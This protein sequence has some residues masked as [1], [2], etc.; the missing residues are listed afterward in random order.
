MQSVQ[1]SHVARRARSLAAILDFYV[2]SRSEA[3]GRAPEEVI[4]FGYRHY[5][6]SPRQVKSE[7]L[8]FG[9]LV[10]EWSPKVLVEIG[11]HA[12]GTFFVLCRCAHPQATVISIDLPGARFSG[13][14]PK[15][16]EHLLP[17]M[18]LKT[19][20]LHRLRGNSHESRSLIWLQSVLRGRQVDVMLIDGDH[21]YKGVKEDFAM[22]SPHVRK[23]GI[24][25]LH[26]IVDHTR[27]PGCEVN[28]FW[29]E[30]KESY[31]HDELIEDPSQGWAGIG[32]LY[33]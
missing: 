13:G 27:D 24:I 29:R 22:Y 17:R 11:T 7:I 6:V 31:R 20:T 15:F 21:T 33:L 18:P 28:L 3:A 9:R 26:D 8:R 25:A 14:R 10:R 4:E 23:G 12:G 2:H 16:V 19:Q 5:P 30:I 32:V 1:V